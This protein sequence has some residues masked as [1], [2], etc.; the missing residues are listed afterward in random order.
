MGRPTQDAEHGFNPRVDASDRARLGSRSPGS[1]SIA[2]PGEPSG[3]RGIMSRSVVE[4]ACA[5]VGQRFT[6]GRRPAMDAGADA[7]IGDPEADESMAREYRGR[8]VLP[9][10]ASF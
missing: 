3:S 4:H 10:E 5:A 9:D 2:S 1:L 7:F 6:L 8:F